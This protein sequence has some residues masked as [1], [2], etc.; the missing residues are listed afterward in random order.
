MAEQHLSLKIKA[1]WGFADTG[2]NVFFITKQLLVFAFMVQYLAVPV[3]LAGLVTSGILLFDIITDPLIGW[4]SDRTVSRFGRRLPYM[5]FGVILMALSVVLLFAVPGEFV[6]ARA[7][8]WVAGFFALGTVGFTLVVIPYSAMPVEMTQDP[9]QRSSLMAFRMAS[10]SLGL[11][12][13]GGVFPIFV[14]L[15]VANGWALD[16]RGG[17]FIAALFMVPL[18]I[19]PVWVACFATRKAPRQEAGESQSLVQQFR[20]VFANRPF[21]LLVVVY[22]F[23]TLGI[24]V[25]TAG[26]PFAAFYLMSDGGGSALSNIASSLGTQSFA[27]ACF[28]LGSMVSQPVWLW[29]SNRLGKARALLIGVL[30]YVVVLLVLFGLLPTSELPGVML[31]IVAM[32]FMNGA[33]Q[34]IPWAMMPDLIDRPGQGKSSHVEGS[35]TAIWLFGQKVGSALGPAILGLLL[36]SVGWLE[37]S[38]GFIDQS[39]EALAV[40]RLV[41]TLLPAILLLGAIGVY[42]VLKEKV[43][44]ADG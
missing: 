32:G 24:T 1:G 27:F 9:K 19:G 8:K 26:I 31:V 13:A 20:T 15:A 25:I 33:Y 28:V 12:L 3:G 37:T 16:A 4:M 38:N 39:P 36:A 2:I 14:G 34:Q 6:G 5:F 22:A 43:G 29:V 30:G 11:L 23:M 17:H 10:A 21:M 42:F 41:M 44:R 35:F 40:L 7:A 18:M